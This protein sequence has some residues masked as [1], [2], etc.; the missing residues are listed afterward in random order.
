M[1]S[2]VVPSVFVKQNK[3]AT[4]I[5]NILRTFFRLPLAALSSHA[6]SAAPWSAEC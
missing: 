5:E 4:D 6:T 3:N 2:T 1:K